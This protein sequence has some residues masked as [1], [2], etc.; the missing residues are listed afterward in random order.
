MQWNILIVD[1]EVEVADTTSEIISGNKIRF[2]DG[3]TIKCEIVNSFDDAI[4]LIAYTNFDLLVLD[5]KDDKSDSDDGTEYSGQRVLNELRK[6]QFT[7]VV[8]YT[9]FAQKLQ[10]LVSPFI[11]VVVKG[12]DPNILRNEI[13]SIFDTQLPQ[14]LKHI[15]EEQRKYLWDHVD[16]EWE[17]MDLQGEFKSEL[18]FLL[19]R[20]LANA[21]EG[22][23]IRK[24]FDPD[25]DGQGGIAHPVE[26][27][28]WPPLGDVL[29]FGDILCK[30]LANGAEQ[31]FIVLNPA[32][33]FVQCKAEQALLAACDEISTTTEYME[34]AA[35][36]KDKKPI[37]KEKANSLNKLI[38][39]N[40]QGKNVQ[41]ERYKFLPKTPFLPDLVIDYQHL[42]QLSVQEINEK[43]GF[44]RVASLDTPFAEAVQS[45]FIRYYGRVGTP[46]LEFVALATRMVDEMQE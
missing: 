35:L 45:R 39:D 36:K 20:R 6:R 16:K 12:G 33:D 43:N 42:S 1:D 18:A 27:Y 44:K 37:S 46:D 22:K 3:S 30:T 24:F 21:L 31:Y 25:Y 19:A 2:D 13:K 32:C 9:G 38:S 11:K 26:L 15:Q 29:G 40:R 10:H 5:L 17:K 28:V 7:P 8:F 34:I 4:A 23:V 14:L 41:A